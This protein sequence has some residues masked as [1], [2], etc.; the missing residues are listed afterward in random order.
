M[1]F[2]EF[3]AVNTRMLDKAEALE[4]HF[5]QSIEEGQEMH[6]LFQEVIPAQHSRP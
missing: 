5:R 1:I 3:V 2:L 4:E 6:H